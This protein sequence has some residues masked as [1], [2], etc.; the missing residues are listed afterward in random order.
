MDQ[1]IARPPA[2]DRCSAPARVSAPAAAPGPESVP[3]PASNSA[4]AASLRRVSSEELLAGA[5]ELEITHGDALYRLRLTAL[6]K[7]ILTK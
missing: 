5:R 6:G 1:P 4:F 3:D 2:F 7:L